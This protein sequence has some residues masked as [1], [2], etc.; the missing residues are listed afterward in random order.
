MR[1][2][3]KTRERI[4]E[5]A[6]A[7]FASKG[8]DGATVRDIAQAVGVSEGALYRHFRSKEEI[9]R[10]IF[11]TRYAALARDVLEIGMGEG[12]LES[13]VGALTRRFTTLFDDGACAVRLPARQPAPASRRGLG[14]GGREPGRGAA[15]RVRGGDPAPR[16]RAGRPRF[17][18]RDGAGAGGAAGGVQHLQAAPG[19]ARP[20]CA[21]DHPGPDGDPA[22]DLTGS[23]DP[24]RRRILSRSSTEL[25][26]SRIVASRAAAGSPAQMA[27]ITARCS[28]SALLR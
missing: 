26:R 1:D 19:A 17:A 23:A 24:P 8:V 3:A 21:P 5:A 4:C 20:I 6:L 11:A 14:R 15:G 25:P 2:G 16:D 22:A 27:S 10:D 28:A 9:A 12:G 18:R 7:L 13:R